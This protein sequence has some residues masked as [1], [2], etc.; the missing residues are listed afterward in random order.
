MIQIFNDGIVEATLY[1]ERW[2]FI[3]WLQNMHGR[4][5][6]MLLKDVMAIEEMILQ[7]GWKGW[8]TSSDHDHKD[9][10]MLIHKVGAQFMA[11]D[12]AFV[13]FNKWLLKEGDKYVRRSPKRTPVTAVSGS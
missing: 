13:Y 10:Q 1:P 2:V 3:R 9:M 12:A 4:L 11:K 8:F 6:R 5:Q 7:N